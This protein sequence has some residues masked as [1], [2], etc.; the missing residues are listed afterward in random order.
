MKLNKIVVLILVAVLAIGAPGCGKKGKSAKPIQ[1]S[2]QKAPKELQ[3]MKDDL[4]K[5]GQ[6]LEKRK[7]SKIQISTP[8]SSSAN[9]KKTGA[10]SQGHT[11]GGTGSASGQ[12]TAGG[13]NQT[14]GQGQGQGQGQGGQTGQ[15]SQTSQTGQQTGMTPQML[16]AKE[17]AMAEQEWQ[18]ELKLVRSLHQD[19][20]TLEAKASTKGMS[21]TIQTGMEESLNRLTDAVS[22]RK[23]LTSELAA[24]QVFRYYVDIS[25]LLYPG[26]VTELDRL[27]YY[28]AEARLQAEN[29]DWTAASEA[30]AKAAEVWRSIGYS[31]KGAKGEELS[32]ME[33]ALTDVGLAVA[34]QNTIVTSIKT[35]I[36]L[37]NLDKLEKVAAK[38]A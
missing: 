24:N 26:T 1:T 28:I 4:A 2:T 29:G 30:S 13:Q 14:G 25:R 5:L 22:G 3:K 16:A 27:R 37:K 8:I 7:S 10:A 31:I 35:E 15:S 11:S 6:M 19:W 18:Q 20:N 12:N 36:A 23:L 38:G 9:Q 33:H 32:Q 21:G 17:K 34:D